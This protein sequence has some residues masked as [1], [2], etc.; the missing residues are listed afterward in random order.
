MSGAHEADWTGSECGRERS[1]WE[2]MHKREPFVQGYSARLD[3]LLCVA[4]K[5]S[6][7]SPWFDSADAREWRAG[8]HL[9]DLEVLTG[10]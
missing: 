10:G 2:E 7:H 9:A 3:G 8:W 4:P 5:R 1:V 6:P